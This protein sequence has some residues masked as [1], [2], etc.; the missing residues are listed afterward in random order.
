MNNKDKILQWIDVV[1]SELSDSEEVIGKRILSKCGQECSKSCGS[2]ENALKVRNNAKDKNDIDELFNSFK[3]KFYNTPRLSKEGRVITLI[4][5]ECGCPM[6]E[7][8]IKNSFL[9]N[10]TVGYTRQIYETL[11]GRSVEINLESSMLKGDKI[12]KQ[13]IK[14]L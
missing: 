6:V 8:G 3:E 12:C 7:E 9:C 14:I 5:E 2:F 13:I 1:L 4:Y 11:F 10:C